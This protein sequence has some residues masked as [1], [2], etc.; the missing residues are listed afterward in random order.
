MGQPV[1]SNDDLETA[2]YR[3]V[4]E[5]INNAAS[6]SQATNAAVT[7]EFEPDRLRADVD[8]DGVGFILQD[9]LRDSLGVGLAGMF[10]RAEALGGQLEVRSE[11]GSG[12]RV[13]LEVSNDTG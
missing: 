5:A 1:H 4:Q 13:T 7:L 2:V 8:D 10:E 12:T 9:V 6:H 11:P 3:I